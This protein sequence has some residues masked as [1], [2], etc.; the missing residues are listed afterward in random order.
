[1]TLPFI[2]KVGSFRGR[3]LAYLSV[4]FLTINTAVRI[5][6]HIGFSHSLPVSSSM[7]TGLL[8]GLVNDCATL[9]FA[10][11]LPAALIL[12]PTD[13]FLRRPAGKLYGILIIFCF[14]ST[15]IFTAAAEY[16]FWDEFS[17][18]FNFIAVSQF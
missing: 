17:S 9:S 18:R 12:L 6:L 10:L 16:F 2:K 3:Y 15:L 11:L 4:L 5:A 8:L 14:T 7:A 1:M 13:R